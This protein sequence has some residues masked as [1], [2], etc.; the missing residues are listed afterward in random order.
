M[1]SRSVLT[2]LFGLLACQSVAAQPISESCKAAQ[3]LLLENEKETARLIHAVETVRTSE[4]S[5]T[6]GQSV[7]DVN[8]VIKPYRMSPPLEQ[9]FVAAIGGPE[10][11]YTVYRS[12]DDTLFQFTSIQGSLKCAYDIW[13][14]R[15]GEELVELTEGPDL[16]DACNVTRLHGTFENS[17]VL[18]QYEYQ[19]DDGEVSFALPG[20]VLEIRIVVLK[21][22]R[23]GDVCVIEPE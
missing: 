10:Y 14:V 1:S 15:R 16:G 21:P 3:T 11:D 23:F 18:I 7:D 22:E 19:A 4:T 20:K 13:A 2:L 9:V 8:R 6:G 5:P 12:D 17:P